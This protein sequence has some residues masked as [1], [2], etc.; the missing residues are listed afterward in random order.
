MIYGFCTFK[1][2]PLPVLP[3]FPF[4]LWVC[5]PLL[6]IVT[7][8]VWAPLDE[9]LPLL[10]T[11]KALLPDV[12]PVADVLWLAVT[13]KAYGIPCVWAPVLVV[14]IVPWLWFVELVLIFTPCVCAGKFPTAIVLVLL[15]PVSATVLKS[16]SD[17][18]TPTIAFPFPNLSHVPP[19]N[20][21]GLVGDTDV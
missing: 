11:A 18:S 12:Y 20:V 9:T 17:S 6:F 8:W 19:N 5:P 16:S 4:T 3:V 7:W 15:P 2:V 10:R 13:T 1:A 14:F 21:A